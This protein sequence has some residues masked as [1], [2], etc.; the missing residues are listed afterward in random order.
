MKR[1]IYAVLIVSLLTSAGFCFDL[2]QVRVHSRYAI[3]DVTSTLT[4]QDFRF[5]DYIMNER[6]NQIQEEVCGFTRCIYDT[7]HITPSTGTAEYDKPAGC[8]TI[9]RVAYTTVGGSTISYKQLDWTTQPGLDRDIPRWESTTPG[10][11]TKYYERGKKIGLYPRPSSVYSSS[12]AIK[13]NFYKRADT[14]DSDDDIPFDGM[15]ELYAY[16]RILVVGVAAWCSWDMHKWADYERFTGEYERMMERMGRNIKMKP[17][18]QGNMHFRF[19]P[20]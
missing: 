13:I 7:D 17:D 10:I 9:D 3:G 18:K 6:I 8:I 5:P 4:T 15:Y 11:P 16:H 19:N 20:N 2:E 1:F 12:S 14:M